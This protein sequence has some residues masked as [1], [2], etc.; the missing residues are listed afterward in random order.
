MRILDE[1]IIQFFHSQHFTIVSTIDKNGY[2]HNA[3]KGI[4]E[5]DKDG[6]LY[7][8]DL[9]TAKTY[10]NLKDNP[11][12]SITAVDEHRFIGYCLKGKAKI[13]TRD[14]VSRRILELWES[15]ITSR[16]THRLLKNMQGKKGHASH[17]EAL[18]P[19]PTYLI[20]VDVKE[21]ID[22]TPSH[23]RQRG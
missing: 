2:P 23:I 13:I 16:I 22:L 7:L 17:P 20:V 6:R 5:I 21:V 19:K 12:I 1:D 8:F 14:K 15:K 9:Y 3:C 11:H 18:L 10:E 4:V